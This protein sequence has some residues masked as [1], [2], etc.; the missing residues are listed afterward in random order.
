M[1]LCLPYVFRSLQGFPGDLAR[2]LG[3]DATLGDVLQMLD[4]LYSIMMT[5]NAVSK[6]LYSVKQGMG[7][8]MAEFVVHLFQ[9]IQILQM[10]YPSRIQQEHM[11]EVNWHHFYRGL[12]PEY[13][14]MLAHKVDG[15]N[16][17]TYSK[18]LL[19]AHKLERWVE[20]RTPCSQ[21]TL[22]LGVQK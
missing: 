17:V 5:F 13:W 10:K 8:K 11:E 14:Q 3:D 7:E 4:K 22:L 19:A 9:Q 15:E 20:A 16:P 1:C 2:S 12:S 21:K 18:L 6:E